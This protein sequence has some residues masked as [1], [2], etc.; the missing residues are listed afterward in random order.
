MTTRRPQRIDPLPKGKRGLPAAPKPPQISDAE[1]MVMNAVWD[2]APVTA[3][4]VVQSLHNRTSWKPKTIHTLLRRL[5]HKGA[6]AF[7]KQGREHVFRPLFDAGQV[8]HAASRSLLQRL[9]NGKLAPFLA[10]FLEQEKL[11][12]EVIAELRQILENNQ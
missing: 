2:L 7:E 9:F 11:S 6:V 10:C 3:N 1:W 12:P 4:Q 5:V 8:R